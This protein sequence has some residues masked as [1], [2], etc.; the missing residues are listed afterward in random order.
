MAGNL[1][2]EFVNFAPFLQHLDRGRAKIAD[3]RLR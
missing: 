1:L 2:A 3:R